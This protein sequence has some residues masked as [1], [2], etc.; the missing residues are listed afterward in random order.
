MGLG[1]GIRYQEKIYSEPRI[2][3]PGV[4]KSLDPGSGSAILFFKAVLWIHEI[5]IWFR[6]RSIPLTNG[7]ED[8]NPAI[9]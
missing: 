7:S 2:Q 3:N 1:S 4:K 8:P 6:V 5:L 9:L